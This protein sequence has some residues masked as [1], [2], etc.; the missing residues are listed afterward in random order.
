MSHI[1]IYLWLWVLVAL[2]TLAVSVKNTADKSSLTEPINTPLLS[3]VT[4]FSSNHLMEGVLMIRSLIAQNYTGLIDVYL[5]RQPNETLPDAMQY[6]LVEELQKSPLHANVIEYE[7]AEHYNTYCFKPKVIQDFLVRATKSNMRPRV[8]MWTDAST[9]FQGNPDIWAN[10]IQQDGIDFAGRASLMG[11]SE[12]THVAT[13]KYFNMSRTKFKDQ[14]EVAAT[15]FL[16]N[17]MRDG[18]VSAVL[19][20]WF[21]CAHACN[22]CMAPVGSSKRNSLGKEMKGPPS[23]EYVAHRQDQSVLGLLV[24]DWLLEHGGSVQL[25]DQKYMNVATRRGQRATSI[26]ISNLNS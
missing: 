20:P 3:V 24:Y 16:V 10:A 12:N 13:Y 11:M 19:Q 17:L 6:K 1:I 5:M 2:G 26:S 23:T 8:L 14:R 25:N 21:D 9:R 15:H 7:A 22:T 18:V 4:A